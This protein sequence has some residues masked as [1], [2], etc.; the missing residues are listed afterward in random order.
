MTDVGG[1]GP[2][3]LPA[4]G[5]AEVPAEAEAWRPRRRTVGGVPLSVALPGVPQ[6]LA[7]RWGT[8]GTA[9][10]VWLSFLWILVA[11][12]GRVLQAPGGS[13][14]ERL[15][16]A[17]L[18]LGL[19]GAWGWSLHDVRRPAEARLAGIGQWELAVRAFSRNRT[20]VVGAVAILGFYLLAL[21]TPLLAAFDPAAQGNLLTE[22]LVAPSA[23]HPLGTDQFARDVLSRLLYGAR[24]SLAIGF[25]AV[26]ISV[27]IGTLLGAVSGFFGGWVDAAVMR[28]VDV[29]IAFP[30][31]VLLILII[32]LFEPSIFLIVAVL[33]LTQWPGTAR[34]VRGEVLSLREREFVLAARALGFGR[35]RIIGRHVIP[36]VLAPVIVAATLGIGNTIVLEAGLS[37]LGL[38]VQPPTPSWGTMVADGRN[39]L[40]DAWWISTF[41]GLAIVLVVLSFNLVGDG[42]RDALDPRMRKG[43]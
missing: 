21:L 9:L 25:V 4:G 18:G 1:R 8:G 26:G 27:T 29:V 36:N 5:P 32:A 39:V 33:G 40:I 20:A 42:L 3:P 41:P 7:G 31:L 35:I 6:L 19:V 14:D 43:G 34:I 10:L 28:F 17:C 30:R 22:R 13:L 11:Q 23:A 15:A 38:G 24:V 2:L 16:V 37:F 12:R